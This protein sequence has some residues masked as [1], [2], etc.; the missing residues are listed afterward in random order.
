MF[1]DEALA[2][3]LRIRLSKEFFAGFEACIKSLK[4]DGIQS[5]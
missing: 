1:R 3:L 4:V 5:V 2:A